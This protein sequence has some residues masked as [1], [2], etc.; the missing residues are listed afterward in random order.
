MWAVFAY[1]C[2]FATCLCLYAQL[3]LRYT[4]VLPRS[5]TDCTRSSRHFM[6]TFYESIPV[7]SFMFEHGC[8]DTHELAGVFIRIHHNHETVGGLVA[9]YLCSNPVPFDILSIEQIDIVKS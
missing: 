8:M 4:H 1:T 7:R 3:Y 2:V 5:L 6:A 9:D